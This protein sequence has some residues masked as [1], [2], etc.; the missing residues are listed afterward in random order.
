MTHPTVTLFQNITKVYLRE[1]QLQIAID[2]K[3]EPVL[4]LRI[5][6]IIDR[7]MDGADAKLQA[8]SPEAENSD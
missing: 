4:A 7:T 6:E 3:D 8:A 5:V 2:L 1:L